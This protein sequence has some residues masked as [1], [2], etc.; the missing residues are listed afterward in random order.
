[1]SVFLV[2][3]KISS[4]ILLLGAVACLAGCRR[5]DAKNFTG[6][7]KE[8][9]DNA[10][11]FQIMPNGQDGKYS[12][13]FCGPGGCGAPREDGHNTFITNDP[14]YVVVSESEIKIR[15]SNGWEFITGVRPIRTQS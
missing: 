9:C 3:V 12:V 11:G 8:N 7:W 15:R 10:F 13:V 6:F 1:M 5:N 2:N 14:D 4:A